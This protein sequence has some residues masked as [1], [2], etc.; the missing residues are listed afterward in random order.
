M[1]L[2][3]ELLADLEEASDE[4][5]QEELKHLIEKSELKQEDEPMQVDS[6]GNFF[7]CVL[8]AVLKEA[9]RLQACARISR[10]GTLSLFR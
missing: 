1:S 10:F 9:K 6:K 4:E 5:E 2:A 7:F 3:D 8:L